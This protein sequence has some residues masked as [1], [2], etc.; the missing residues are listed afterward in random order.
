MRHTKR[1][2]HTAVTQQQHQR[3][4]RRTAMTWET[5]KGKGCYYTRT[6]RRNGR[7]IREYVGS[8]AL[9]TLLAQI[10]AT[11]REEQAIVAEIAAEEQAERDACYARLFGPLDALEAASNVLV[12][13]ALTAAGYV[14]HDRG[15]WRMPRGRQ[16]TART[17]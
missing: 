2:M 13:E 14:Q 5:R 9:A 16:K 4:R 8:G 10:D 7:R 3:G 11:A 12:R 1:R 6:H 15:D 17:R